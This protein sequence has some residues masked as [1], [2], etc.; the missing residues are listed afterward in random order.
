MIV[1]AYVPVFISA[2]VYISGY[3]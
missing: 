2:I 1:R 3:N